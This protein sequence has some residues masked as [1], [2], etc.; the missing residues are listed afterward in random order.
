[1][2]KKILNFFYLLEKNR[3]KKIEEAEQISKNYYISK[4]YVDLCKA[5]NEYENLLGNNKE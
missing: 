3:I 1:M 5:I 2:Y 4:S